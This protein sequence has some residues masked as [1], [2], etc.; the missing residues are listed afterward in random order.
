[1]KESIN[2]R[3]TYPNLVGSVL[4]GKLL[5]ES[6]PTILPNVRDSRLFTVVRNVNSLGQR[7]ALVFDSATLKET[8]AHAK[9]MA[10][11]HGHG[12]TKHSGDPHLKIAATL[13]FTGTLYKDIRTHNIAFETEQQ[14]GL[15]IE[16]ILKTGATKSDLNKLAC[17]LKNFGRAVVNDPNFLHYGFDPLLLMEVKD[18]EGEMSNSLA[19]AAVQVLYFKEPGHQVQVE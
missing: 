18:E 6:I 5:N 12:T 1:M 19:N 14:P 7:S 3:L 16:E 11:I 4:H 15:T 9:K 10:L 8:P 2:N 17:R 13:D